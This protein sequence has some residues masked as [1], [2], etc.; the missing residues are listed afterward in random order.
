MKMTTKFTCPTLEE[1]LSQQ[2]SGYLRV[3]YKV[4][5]YWSSDSISIYISRSWTEKGAWDFKISHS[6]GGRDTNEVPE[7]EVATYNFALAMMDAAVLVTKLKESYI[8]VIEASYQEYVA[9]VK[10]AEEKADE[11]LRKVVEAEQARCD[12]DPALGAYNAKVMIEKAIKL[13]KDSGS[14]IIKGQLR[15]EDEEYTMIAVQNYDRTSFYFTNK[16]RSRNGRLNRKQLE[17]FLS[18]KMS[19]RVEIAP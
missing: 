3:P 15:G 10:E 6:S 18:T 4:H 9:R 13:A 14:V 5:G 7:D 11:A 2:N 17:E 12:A 16:Y 19:T 8:P 1:I